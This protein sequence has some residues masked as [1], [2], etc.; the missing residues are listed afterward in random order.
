MVEYYATFHAAAVEFSLV[1]K[2]YVDYLF[3]GV[4]HIV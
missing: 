2:I 4:Q 3:I 1:S